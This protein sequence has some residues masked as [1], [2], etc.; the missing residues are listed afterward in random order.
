MK[1]RHIP[2]KNLNSLLAMTF[3]IFPDRTKYMRAGLI[4][5][6]NMK[7]VRTVIMYD[8]EKAA[9]PLFLVVKPPVD[10]VEK[11]LHTASNGGIPP[12]TSR[13]VSARVRKA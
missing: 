9:I 6:R 10:T 13:I 3:L 8:D 4:A 2:A 1:T 11:E 5:A 12:I 7:T